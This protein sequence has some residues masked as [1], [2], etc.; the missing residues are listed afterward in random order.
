[1]TRITVPLGMTLRTAL[2]VASGPGCITPGALYK[3]SYVYYDEESDGKQGRPWI[4]IPD[5]ESP[6]PDYY[7]LQYC[8]LERLVIYALDEVWEPTSNLQW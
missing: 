3:N 5:I 4:Y 8:Q 6:H 2:E 1:M 7:H